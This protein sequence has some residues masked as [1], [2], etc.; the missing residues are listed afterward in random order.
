[1]G[2]IGVGSISA[3]LC[4]P[5]VALL[6]T[7]RRC[8]SPH[9]VPTDCRRPPLPSRSAALPLARMKRCG[10]SLAILDSGTGDNY[11]CPDP[12][13]VSLLNSLPALEQCRSA[14]LP[15][16]VR[17]QSGGGRPHRCMECVQTLKVGVLL[18]AGDNLAFAVLQSHP[19]ST[20]F[21]RI[22]EAQPSG[23][24]GSGTPLVNRGSSATGTDERLTA[25]GVTHLGLVAPTPLAWSTSEFSQSGPYLKNVQSL[26]PHWE[27]P[28]VHSLPLIGARMTV[29]GAE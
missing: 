26:T 10:D 20:E 19:F 18:C 14:V 16:S 2:A 8:Q 25:H 22:A 21:V 28:I 12:I 11:P 1:M 23:S 6:D 9:Q 5:D 7:G 3:N 17:R 15:W 13:T 24:G 29:G 4:S 27:Y